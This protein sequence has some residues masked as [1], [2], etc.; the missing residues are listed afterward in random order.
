MKRESRRRGAGCLALPHVPVRCVRTVELRGRVRPSLHAQRWQRLQ[1]GRCTVCLTTGRSFKVTC[2]RNGERWAASSAA[3]LACPS[4]CPRRV[5]L[6]RAA[7]A[8]SDLATPHEAHFRHV[9]CRLLPHAHYD[10]EKA[11][12]FDPGKSKPQRT[13]PKRD[14][15]NRFLSDFVESFSLALPPSFALLGVCHPSLGEAKS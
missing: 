4:A 14:R 5:A 13:S 11:Q 1:A 3:L 10:E 12:F 7:G 6:L 8:L 15:H 9:L 2:T